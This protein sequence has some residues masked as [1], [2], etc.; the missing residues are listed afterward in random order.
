MAS[1]PSGVR[2]ASFEVPE[3]VLRKPIDGVLRAL[4][5]GPSWGAVRKLITTGKVSKNGAL[6]TDPLVWVSAGD[7]VVI[8]MTAK[9]PATAARLSPQ[10][11]VHLDAQLVVVRKPA[12]VS[13]VPFE[14]GES[15][16]LDQLVRALLSRESRGRGGRA[17]GSIGVVHRLDKET[18]GLLVFART[19]AA[20][21]HLSQQ[22]RDHTVHRR[23]VALAHGALE[24][25]Y[26]FRSRLVADRGDGLR[27]STELPNAGQLAITHAR[28]LET[29]V[30]AS[31]VECQ[32]ET[33]RTHQI[34]IHLAE[35]GHPLVGE[36]VYIRHFR[37]S[38]IAAP[39]TM[40]HAK[41]LGFL[42]PQTET[43]MRFEDP[44]PED[45]ERTL[46]SLRPG[47]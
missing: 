3:G 6:V 38:P 11:I 37:G 22:F 28:P 21:K 19:L 32:L 43:E 5:A 35:A 8:C 36:R 34:R 24:G 13:T 12:G 40:L 23:Y 15:G 14:E 29:L 30:G 18:T 44:W 20:K 7:R 9:R 33:G 1:D 39:R 26:T 27:G 46:R 42:H 25:E 10:V 31:L 17:Q 45:F 4:M 16:T 2:D 47:G 41:E